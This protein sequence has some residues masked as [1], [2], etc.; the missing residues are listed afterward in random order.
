MIGQTLTLT[1]A[2]AACLIIPSPD[3]R[4]A[5]IENNGTTNA[6]RLSIDGGGN[7]TFGQGLTGT[8]PTPTT[9]I[10]LKAGSAYQIVY[11]VGVSRNPIW[12]IMSTGSTTL[13]LITDD[14]VSTAPTP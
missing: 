9:G 1:S 11:D 13:D 7:S 14:P 5:R 2:A 4:I 10:L 3:C 12:G 6:V 8:D